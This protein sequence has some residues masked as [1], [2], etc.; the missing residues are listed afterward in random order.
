MNFILLDVAIGL[1]TIFALVALMCAGV[2]ELMAAMLNLRGKTLWEGVQSILLAGHNVGKRAAGDESPAD[3]QKD[4]GGAIEEA[5]RSHPLIV[6]QVPDSF[7]MAGLFLWA[8]GRRRPTANIA[9][10]RPSYLSSSTFATALAQTLQKLYQGQGHQ[11]ADFAQTIAALPDGPLKSTLRGFVASARG[12]AERTRRAVEDWFDEAMARV[13]G[14]YKRRTQAML[15]M[16]G[17]VVAVGL[18]IDSMHVANQLWKEPTLRAA[19]VAQAT[20]V[21]EAKVQAKAYDNLHGEDLINKAR[22]DLVDLPSSLPMGWPAAWWPSRKIQKASFWERVTWTTGT[23]FDHAGD[24]LLLFIGWLVTA[25]AVSFGAPFW[26]DLLGKLIPLRSTGAKPA[27]A[28][29]GAKSAAERTVSAAPSAQPSGSQTS[30]PAPA[31]ATPAAGSFRY[32]LNDFEALALDD[33]A[34]IGVKKKLGLSGPTAS[35]GLLDQPTRDAIRAA[36]KK[37]GLP[38]T[39]QLSAMLLEL[40]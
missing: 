29:P 8:A 22:Q 10:S 19:M 18:N 2:Q 11:F 1:A 34:I 12:D 4:P 9:S 40:L 20:K 28:A 27:E 36:Q 16:V 17:F 38:E 32:A 37:R 33:Q 30:V 24:A 39:G 35:T 5:M 31:G 14:W 7:G 6:G 23:L 25:A 26:F 21:N 15:F 3:P 13:T